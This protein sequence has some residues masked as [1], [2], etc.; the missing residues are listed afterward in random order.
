MTAINTRRRA[1]RCGKPIPLWTHSASN[2]PAANQEKNA[3]GQFSGL[4]PGPRNAPTP[5]APS[6]RPG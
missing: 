3:G 4:I 5:K 6:P 1:K 2:M